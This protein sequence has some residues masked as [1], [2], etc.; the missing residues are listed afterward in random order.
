MKF[1]LKFIEKSERSA[2]FLCE[3]HIYT[4]IDKTESKYDDAISRKN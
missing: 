3:F 2:W 1:A 4:P